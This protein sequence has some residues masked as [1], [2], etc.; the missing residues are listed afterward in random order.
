LRHSLPF[1]DDAGIPFLL[2]GSA[3]KFF[4][5]RVWCVLVL[6]MGAEACVRV[7]CAQVQAPASAMPAK[8]APAGDFSKEA[9]V[10]ERVSTRVREEA[11]GTG[12]HESSTRVRIQSE[13]GV[14]QMAVL[15]F[16]Y[17]ASNQQAEIGYVRVIKPDGTMVVT[18]DYNVQDLP[19]D[20]SRE[21]PM[22][23]DIHQKHVAVKGLGVGDTLEYKVTLRTVK[24]EVPGQFWLEYS[25]EK[26]LIALD[27]QLDLDLPDGKAVTVASPDAQPTITRAQ[28][29]VLYR[30]SSSN[31]TRPDPDKPKSI[32]HWKPSV[33][34]TTFT[35]WDQVGA[36][37]WSLQ[38]DEMTVTP[39]IQAKADALTKGLTTD[40]E[41]MRAIFAA[42]A[43]HTHYIGISFGI[44]RYQPHLAEDVL[45]NEYGDCK[46]KH[47]LLATLLRA[48]GIEAWPVLI[49]SGR[50][51]DPAVPSPAQFDHVIT[52]VPRPNSNPAKLIWMDATEEVAPVGVLMQVLRDKQALA[53]PAG[54][55][56]YLERTPADLP[57][58][59]SFL[60]TAN[61]KLSDKGEFTGRIEQTYHGDV[62]LMMRALFRQVPQ[63]QWKQFVQQMIGNMGFGGETGQPEVSQV[64]Q[65][66]EP[67][68]FGFDYTRQKYS[69]WEDRRINPPMPG[70]GWELAPGTR[71]VKPADDV[72]LGSTGE[73]DYKTSVQMAPGWVVTTPIGIDLKEDWAE[74][75]SSY[76]FANGTFTAERKLVMKKD[77]IPLADWDK[78]RAFREAIYTDVVKMSEVAESFPLTGKPINGVAI[79]PSGHSFADMEDDRQL[80]SK[81]QPVRDAMATLAATPQVEKID[82]MRAA[83]SCRGVM[84]DFE[85][86]SRDLDATDD[87]SVHWGQM[88]ANVWTCLGW[89]SL[90]TGERG[91]AEIYLRAAWQA[92]QSPLAGYELARVLEAKG[93]KSGAAHLY[94]LASVTRSGGLLA[95]PPGMDL[96][97][98]TADA[99]KSLT[100]KELTATP[101][102]NNM[103]KGSLQEELDNAREIKQLV[104]VTKL[105]GEATFLMA[106]EDGKPAKAKFLSGEKTMASLAPVVEQAKFTTGLPVGSKARLLREAMVIC[107][108][109]AGCEAELLLAG[110][111]R[112]SSNPVQILPGG[113]RQVQIQVAAP[114]KP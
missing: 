72:E 3:M 91:V 27:E 80:S 97:Q 57:F 45:S 42:V 89:G 65:T 4:A 9:L 23:S 69:E 96:H 98:L 114:P 102:N 61:G 73:Q 18:P 19:A 14:K 66:S 78:Y 46:D 43:L 59:Q 76:N 111:M 60:F 71:E 44:G 12:F 11:D 99:Y 21:A 103:Y 93:D 39:A 64:E 40:D 51:L 35:G 37:Y 25:F 54:K 67:F 94:E 29:R 86:Q 62:E 49:S 63:S 52:V 68:H 13:A 47:T 8:A 28:G 7:S 70:V 56:A 58:P 5:V 53:I 100:G 16:T 36:W 77:K 85:L 33:Q 109:Y 17:T 110:K 84:H 83:A 24:P 82:R 48:A 22:Y 105:S 81:L 10:V 31:L 101:L 87:R 6:L 38:K 2:A 15:M 92:S 55:P 113:A 88:L 95:P 41:K 79:A 34:V 50:E 112:V 107:T 1:V 32:K 106:Y 104:R 74:Y 108:P 75:H 30:W 26:N 90:E 20:V